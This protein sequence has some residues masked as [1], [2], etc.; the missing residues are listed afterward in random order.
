MGTALLAVA[1]AA[2]STGPF[3][4][5]N[6]QRTE[7]ERNTPAFEEVHVGDGVEA[8]VVVEP[9]Q[10]ARVIVEG[11]SNLVEL[12]RTEVKPG[13]RLGVYFREEDVGH[14]ESVHPLRVRIT[15]PTLK[16]FRRS[17]GGASDLS[18]RID[19]PAF[20]LTASGGG[21][22]RARGFVTERLTL[23]TSGGT[24]TTLEG[25][26]TRLDSEMS[27]G[28][29]LFA[30]GLQTRDARLE[31]SGGGT[32]EV[33]VSDTLRVEASGGADIRIIGAPTVVDRDLSGGSRLHFDSRERASMGARL[34]G[35]VGLRLQSSSGARPP[36]RHRLPR[37]T[38]WCGPCS[39]R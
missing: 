38:A 17:G 30:T 20:L 32:S 4:D 2:C 5:G 33:Q 31:S 15:V 9:D 11:D 27:G 22:I 26:A 34:S 23:E 10:P 3:V 35:A 37:D 13:A 14:W 6:G 25:Q 19:V 8:T 24:E 12:L 18:G 39:G 16:S 28:G 7:S 1:L 36:A 21:T 29:R